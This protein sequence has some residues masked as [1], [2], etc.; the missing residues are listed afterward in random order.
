[1][2]P[3]TDPAT[4]AAS[5][6]GRS[7]ARPTGFRPVADHR[8]LRGAYNLRPAERQQ[9]VRDVADVM[10]R[11]P[12]IVAELL[13]EFDTA[14]E[15]LR[16]LADYRRLSPEVAEALAAN[17]WTMPLRAVGRARKAA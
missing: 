16:R 1:M 12:R 3:F 8:P 9:L 14:D 5:R 4:P 11:G 13:L 7:S 2:H 10:S 15:L 17:D 6:G